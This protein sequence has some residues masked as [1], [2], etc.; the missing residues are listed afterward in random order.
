MV[1]LTIIA[2]ASN[3]CM[4]LEP[5]KFADVLI[6][7]MPVYKTFCL[8]ISTIRLGESFLRAIAVR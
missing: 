6:K 8:E 4:P 2:S 5:C 7:K 1:F 3:V